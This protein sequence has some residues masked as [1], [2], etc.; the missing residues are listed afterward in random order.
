MR[1]LETEGSLVSDGDEELLVKVTFCG[2]SV[3]T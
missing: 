1:R 2:T 3:P